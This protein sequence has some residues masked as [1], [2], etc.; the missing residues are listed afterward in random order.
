M[1]AMARS[2]VLGVTLLALFAS[3]SVLARADDPVVSLHKCLD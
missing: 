1:V 2:A 3:L